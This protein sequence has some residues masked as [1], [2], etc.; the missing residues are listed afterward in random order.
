RAIR[1]VR[2][3]ASEKA[4]IVHERISA[5]APKQGYSS[6][7][8]AACIDTK[9]GD[10]I[11]SSCCREQERHGS[12]GPL[13]CGGSVGQIELRR[14]GMETH[15][16]RSGTQSCR[17]ANE[18]AT[19]REIKCPSTVDRLLKRGRVVAVPISLNAEGADIDPG[20][21]GRKRLNG[22]GW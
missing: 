6:T 14:P 19:S 4:Y 13:E 11:C 12:P 20:G 9:T 21:G 16:P 22:G 3:V 7:V 17:V 1:R 18:V 15:Q 2:A 8:E 10:R 5:R